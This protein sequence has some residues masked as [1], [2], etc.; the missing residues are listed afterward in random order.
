MTLQRPKPCP[1]ITMP[2]NS[3]NSILFSK[4][5]PSGRATVLVTFSMAKS[6]SRS[7]VLVNRAATGP[8]RKQRGGRW[9]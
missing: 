1:P 5:V 6:L 8:S 9:S 4:E 3:K 7:N 2:T